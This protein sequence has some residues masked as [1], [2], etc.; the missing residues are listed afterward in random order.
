MSG[1]KPTTL[2]VQPRSA[3][4]VTRLHPM[5]DA[6]KALAQIAGTTTITP[7]ALR[8]ATDKLG[9]GLKVVERSAKDEVLGL[10]HSAQEAA[11]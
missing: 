5:N 7:E 6:A 3:Y 8:I 9:L 11:P 1:P 2:L 10:L 4:G